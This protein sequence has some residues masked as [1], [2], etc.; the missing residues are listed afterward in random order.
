MTIERRSDNSIPER[1]DRPGYS[2]YWE[3]IVRI[4]GVEL[5]QRYTRLDQASDIV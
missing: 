2:K 1:Q 4:D 3:Y 5:L